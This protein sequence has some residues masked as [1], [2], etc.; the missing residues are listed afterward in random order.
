MLIAPGTK[1]VGKTIDQSGLLAPEAARVLAVRRDDGTLHVSP[2]DDL[3]LEEG[4][5]V[6]ALGTEDQLFASAAL[7]R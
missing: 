2:S 1:A 7:L 4:D 6:I 3:R 5:L